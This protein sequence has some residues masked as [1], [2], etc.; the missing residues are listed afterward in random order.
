MVRCER[1]E[2]GGCGGGALDAFVAAAIL[3]LLEGGEGWLYGQPAGGDAAAGDR[4]I[5]RV[6]EV[7]V[8]CGH[9]PGTEG[10]ED[11]LDGEEAAEVDELQ[12][13][14]FEVEALF[15]SVAELVKG[16]KH[17]LK[18]AGELFFGKEGGGAGGAA[19]FF[20]GDL[21][22]LGA[23]AVVGVWREAGNFG[24]DAAAEVAHG[25]AGELGGGVAGVEEVVGDGDDF[26]GAV[27]VDGL[28]DAF[29]DGVGDGAHELA[30][31]G[32][33]EAGAA[34]ENGRAGDG[35]VHDAEGVA[36]GA[37]AGFGEE[38][39]G[40]FVGIDAFVFG[41]AAE[42]AED[43]GELDGVEGEVLAA[44]A[45]GLGDVFGLGGGHHEDDVVGGLLEG[46]EQGV[47]GGVG[48]LVG[49][50]ED[51]DLVLVA[52]GAVAG[53]VAEFAD[54]VDAAVGGGVDFDDVDGVAGAD[55][56]AGLADFAGLGGGAKR[57]ADGV[58]AVEGAGEDAGDGGFADAAVAARR[59]SRGRCGSGRARS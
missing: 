38:C 13:A 15:L 52:G 46:L 11:L 50:V 48:D 14:E 20:G 10:A 26:G 54:L 2:P 9:G 37:V 28:E 51:V 24:D 27:G 43:V 32:G 21:E 18:E 47:E 58:A 30:D 42:L 41:D 39:E 53:G 49:F 40:A 4:G 12:Q 45:D 55:F 22:E 44:G 57:G 33:V 8:G 35:L 31:L 6:G 59:C 23:D 16:A 34:I 36:H 5:C 17:D 3:I 56:E 25:L 1:R 7:R 19:L 29:E